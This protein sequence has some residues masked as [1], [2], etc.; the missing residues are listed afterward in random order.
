MR[1]LDVAMP[2]WDD[3]WLAYRRALVYGYNLWAVTTTVDP[4]ITHEFVFRLGT[5]VADHHSM[6]LL[7]V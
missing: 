4:R 5:A 6:E 3:A 7:G 1:D 2:A